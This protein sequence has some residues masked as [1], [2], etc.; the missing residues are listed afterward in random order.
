MNHV[1][2]AKKRNVK[3]CNADT[4]FHSEYFTQNCNSLSSSLNDST[5]NK[6]YMF[7]AHKEYAAQKP[8]NVPIVLLHGV[9]NAKETWDDC[10][11]EIA[12]R[13]ASQVFCLDARNH[14]DSEWTETIG[15]DSM[16]EDVVNFMNSRSIPRITIVGHSM[17]GKTGMA[18]AFKY[19]ERLESLIIEDI[20]ARSPSSSRTGISYYMKQK[21]D[22]LMKIPPHA[23]LAEAK[24]FAASYLSGGEAAAKRKLQVNTIA[25]KIWEGRD[26]PLRMTPSG[27]FEWKTNLNVIVNSMESGKWSPVSSD[28]LYEGPVFLIY[29]TKSPFKVLEDKEEFLKQFPKTVYQPIQDGTHSLHIEYPE[30]FTNLVC[31]FILKIRASTDKHRTGI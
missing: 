20:S 17:G 18:F 13:T 21:R 22:V 26:L 28:G 16:A 25:P 14:G 7:I 11:Q 9:T 8:E 30:I 19:P 15:Y 23:E 3:R 24:K 10:A 5:M 31:E 12:N 29:G 1:N 6:S 4:R 2:Q 27:D